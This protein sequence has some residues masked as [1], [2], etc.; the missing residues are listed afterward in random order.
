MSRVSDCVISM[1]R[2]LKVTRDRC[3]L[4]LCVVGDNWH[5]RNDYGEHV[6]QHL[7]E[8]DF[9]MEKQRYELYLSLLFIYLSIYILKDKSSAPSNVKI[10]INSSSGRILFKFSQKM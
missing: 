10:H 7:R 2:R 9:T 1:Q 8:N 6:Y 4:V 5:R 3:S